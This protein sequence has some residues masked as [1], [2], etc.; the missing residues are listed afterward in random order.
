MKILVISGPRTGST[1]YCDAQSVDINFCEELMA[2][3]SRCQ[4][5]EEI[6]SLDSWCFKIMKYHFD[7]VVPDDLLVDIINNVDVI[8]ILR[9]KDKV[10]QAI[11]LAI[12]NTSDMWFNVTYTD[13]N[14]KFDYNEFKNGCHHIL[15]VDEWIDSMITTI[16]ANSQSSKL[17]FVYYEDL[18]LS[19]S[20]IVKNVYNNTIDLD[21][22]N[23]ILKQVMIDIGNE[24]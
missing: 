5:W 2:D 19:Q 16:T 9:R 4:R 18:D 17:E 1:A 14:A 8:K 3:A 12:G 21:R 20:S 6:K 15:K 22:C 23:S 7:H 13:D 11:S 24:K 10:A